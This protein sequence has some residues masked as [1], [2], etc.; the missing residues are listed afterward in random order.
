MELERVVS[1]VI[2]LKRWKGAPYAVQPSVVSV[3]TTEDEPRAPLPGPFQT[4]RRRTFPKYFHDVLKR[5]TNQIVVG[6][7]IAVV[8]GLLVLAVGK[9]VG[10]VP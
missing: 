6:I 9:L 8:G 7:V 10:L 5:Y 2:A 3:K 4:I 1:K